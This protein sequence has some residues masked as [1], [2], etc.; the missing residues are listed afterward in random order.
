MEDVQEAKWKTS[1]LVQAKV[2]RA[3]EEGMK[4][5]SSKDKS[6]VVKF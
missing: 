2:V 5:N 1:S 6:A 4:G 3:G